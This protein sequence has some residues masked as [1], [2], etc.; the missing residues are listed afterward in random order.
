MCRLGHMFPYTGY[1]DDTSVTWSG[2]AHFGEGYELGNKPPVL[3]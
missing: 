3:P 1:N 2:Y